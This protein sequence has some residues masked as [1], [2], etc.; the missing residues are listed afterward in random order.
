MVTDLEEVYN[1]CCL[2]TEPIRVMIQSCTLLDV[3]LTNSP[4][5]FNRCGVYNPEI[6]DHC[7]IYREMKEKVC[8]YKPKIITFRQ[9]KTQTSS[10]LIKN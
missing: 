10:N 5:L 1:L 3:F 8:K 4:E 6:S 9:T 2:I 7:V